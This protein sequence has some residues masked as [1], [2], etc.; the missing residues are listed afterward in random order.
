MTMHSIIFEYELLVLVLLVMLALSGTSIY[1]AVSMMRGLRADD[2]LLE[3][4][5][6]NMKFLMV[7]Q[8]SFSRSVRRALLGSEAGKKSPDEPESFDLSDLEQM[9]A[10]GLGDISTASHDAHSLLSEMAGLDGRNLT[11]WKEANKARIESMLA[12]QAGLHRKLAESQETLDHAQKSIRMLKDDHAR[13]AAAEMRIRSMEQIHAAQ[14]AELVAARAKVGALQ[15]ESTRIRQAMTEQET[16]FKAMHAQYMKER[17]NLAK[18]KLALEERLAALQAS[19]DARVDQM[20]GDE[21]LQRDHD[22]YQAERAALEQEKV[23]LEEKL[24]ELQQSFD[25]TLREKNFIESAFLE[26]DSSLMD[27]RLAESA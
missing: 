25:R 10:E 22:Q 2:A 7:E 27:S 19:F 6:R 15:T 21:E 20:P 9:Q 8:G 5:A 24:Q 17:Q 1:L 26:L 18:D 14:E 23:Q 3:Q 11:A 12:Q 4:I 16:S 13:L